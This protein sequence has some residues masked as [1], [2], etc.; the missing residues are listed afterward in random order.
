[1]GESIPVDK[2]IG[3]EVI[4]ATINKHGSFQFKA[5]KVGK[6]TTLAQIIK[7]VEDAQGSSTHS[8]ASLTL[9]Q[10]ISFLLPF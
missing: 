1:M 3:D 7:V 6:E 10:A 2:T 5:K 9:F 8:A 4:G